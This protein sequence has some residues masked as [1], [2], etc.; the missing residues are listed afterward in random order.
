MKIN[1]STWQEYYIGDLFSFVKGKRLTKDKMID[2]EVNYLGAISEN[3]GVRQRIQ[4]D[5]DLIS[6]PNC[7]TVNYN[8]SVGEAFY[9]HEPFWATDD[10]NILYAKGWS[11]NKYNALFV[12]TVIKA[13]R[14]RFGY[15]RKWTLKKMKETIITL[16]AKKDGTP[17]FEFMEDYIKSLHH[18][19]ITTAIMNQQVKIIPK[20]WKEYELQDIFY[21]KYGINM[22]LVNCEVVDNVSEDAVN[23]VARTS[24]NNGVVAK[25][26][27]IP[28][29]EPQ[30]A[31]TITC[32]GG[33]SVLST[34]IQNR[35]FY[36]G[37]DL[38]LLI[39]KFNMSIYSKL[40]CRTIIEANKYRFSYGRQANKTMPYLK[41]KLPAKQ[42]GAPDFEYM[43]NYIK[44]LP[45]GD[46]I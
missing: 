4:V 34:F 31:E 25:V 13:N 12:I 3:N 39:P 15:G 29:L 43:E 46:R 22:E 30:P 17:D 16:P 24:N 6:S 28:E 44:S 9:Q 36:S 8:G 23:F 7:I 18:K 41:I 10:V 11:M 20:T 33:G 45:Y 32:A 1:T 5:P 37:R 14:Y 19:K 26:K 35:D 27:R 40:F 42:D 2:G 21:I 38:Y